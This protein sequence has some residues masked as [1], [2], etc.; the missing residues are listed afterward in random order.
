[1]AISAAAITA[2]LDTARYLVPQWP[3]P[4]NVCAVSTKRHLQTPD[5]YAVQ[6]FNLAQHVNDDG[7]RVALHRQQL[8]QALQLANE[9][10]WLQ[11]VHGAVVVNAPVQGLVQ[12]DA[13]T[14]KQRQ[15]ACVIMTADCLPVLFCDQAGTRVAAAHAGWRGLSAGVLEQTLSYFTNPAQVLVWL[16]PAIGPQ[17]FVVG[18]EVRDI[19][20]KQNACW[21][22]CFTLYASK[23]QKYLADLYELAR[24][25]LAN[26]GV[27]HFYGGG[28]CTV[29]QPQIFYSHRHNI[30]SGRQASLI[31]L[32]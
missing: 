28:L 31:W 25:R 29:S 27:S 5:S 9:P 16:G 7:Q 17:Q 32:L 3:A 12:A 24:R 13:S 20:L 6:G 22:D 1:M 19:F 10:S 30:G 14:T 8:R 26:K 15:Q 18:S 23:P 11:Q 21:H 4:T 2:A